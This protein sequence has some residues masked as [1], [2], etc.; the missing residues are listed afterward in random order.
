MEKVFVQE[1]VVAPSLVEDVCRFNYKLNENPGLQPKDL[2][3]T[4]AKAALENRLFRCLVR[5]L[6]A[7]VLLKYVNNIAF[8]SLLLCKN[9]S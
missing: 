8:I 7:I 5:D 3:T 2:I 1:H 6:I 9:Y 4:T